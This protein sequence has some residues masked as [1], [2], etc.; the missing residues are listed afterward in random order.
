MKFLRNPI[1]SGVLALVA[2]LV[3]AYQIGRPMLQRSW[4]RQVRAPVVAS[5]TKA[6]ESVLQ[7]AA[8]QAGVGGL[9]ASNLVASPLQPVDSATIVAKAD[10]WIEAPA[11]DPFR[12]LPPPEYVPGDTNAPPSPVESWK[13]KAIWRQTGGRVAAINDGVFAEGDDVDGFRVVRIEGD[14]VWVE[15]TNRIYHLRMP[16]WA[17][18]MTNQ[19]VARR[20]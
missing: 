2:V 20:P 6:A 3:V 5:V 7:Q 4:A 9:L 8:S 19:P 15:G 12:L 17:A 16:S 13:L 11:R 10:G 18:L 1:V 14:V